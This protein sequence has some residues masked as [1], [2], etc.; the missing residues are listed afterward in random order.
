MAE[1]PKAPE[2]S[3][4]LSCPPKSEETDNT[5]GEQKG[6][7]LSDICNLNECEDKQGADSGEKWKLTGPDAAEL[8][9][10]A[11][12]RG[13]Q[14]QQTE[15]ETKIL[16]PSS[17]RQNPLV[18]DSGSMA[19][20]QRP[21]WKEGGCRKA[22]TC[23]FF[24]CDRQRERLVEKEG[25]D[26]A[27][28]LTAPKIEEVEQ[29]PTSINVKIL[30]G[31]LNGSPIRAVFSQSEDH[32]E[33][34]SQPANTQYTKDVADKLELTREQTV[35]T[36]KET[37]SSTM[38]CTDE[39]CPAPHLCSNIHLTEEQC[40]TDCKE[41]QEQSVRDTDVTEGRRDRTECTHTGNIATIVR[42]VHVCRC[43][44]I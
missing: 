44:Q 41:I 32:E 10:S 26:F 3:Q 37:E 16:S 5:S 19:N 8:T 4:A 9:I 7:G 31:S 30:M 22:S 15:S 36:E 39:V 20:E 2:D 12:D 43:F 29:P 11:E 24:E 1:H 25:N 35:N 27:C 34:Q 38:E 14:L 33:S 42:C 17:S 23:K 28:R 18:L 21:K 13:M 6:K 40:E